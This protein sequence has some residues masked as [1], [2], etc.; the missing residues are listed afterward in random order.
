M[1]N[2]IDWI[3]SLTDPS[4]PMSPAELIGWAGGIATAVA[5][6]VTAAVSF[7][8]RRLDQPKAK[9]QIIPVLSDW[10]YDERDGMSGSPK[11]SVEVCNVGTGAARLVSFIGMS[12]LLG[13]DLKQDHS[14]LLGSGSAVEVDV[15]TLST[16]FEQAQILVTWS[17]PRAFL[18]WSKRRRQSFKI[19]KFF[20]ERQLEVYATD[21]TS[22]AY[23]PTK[24]KLAPR[25]QEQILSLD[26]ELESLENLVPAPQ[27]FLANQLLM[28]KLAKA[29]WLWREKLPKKQPE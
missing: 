19:S 27:S 13:V 2:I 14:P 22:G 26:K 20:P 6:V 5:T 21:P 7:W 24:A 3:S 28:R 29:G 8:F 10:Y 23:G 17:E 25:A 11:Y 15:F 18:P 16:K 1:V 4:K 12:C 9:F